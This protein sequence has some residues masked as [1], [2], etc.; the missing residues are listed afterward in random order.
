MSKL[1]D[2]AVAGGGQIARAVQ[3]S[4]REKEQAEAQADYDRKIQANAEERR[5]AAQGLVDA[6]DIDG[7]VEAFFA[8]Q[9]PPSARERLPSMPSMSF[10]SDLV[11]PRPMQRGGGVLAKPGLLAP[12]DVTRMEEQRGQL[13]GADRSMDLAL[14]G[15]PMDIALNAMNVFRNAKRMADET[16]IIRPEQTARDIATMMDN[17]HADLNRAVSVAVATGD[18]QAQQVAMRGLAEMAGIK[19]PRAIT[20]SEFRSAYAGGPR[21]RHAGSAALGTIAGL[22]PGNKELKD[23]I[24]SER[25]EDLVR[26]AATIAQRR[27]TSPLSPNYVDTTQAEQLLAR[28]DQG[29]GMVMT[30]EERTTAMAAMPTLPAASP[31][32]LQ[33]QNRFSAADE[34]G[35]MQR[36]AAREQEMQGRDFR[37]E[38]IAEIGPA[39]ER[40]LFRIADILAAAPSA[41]TAEQR[42]ILLQAAA[43]SPDIQ[44]ANLTDLAK[45]AY[46]DRAM[47]AVMKLFPEEEEALSEL[48]MLRMQSMRESMETENLR[49]QKLQ[50]ALDKEAAKLA[51]QAKRGGGTG[52]SSELMRQAAYLTKN[53]PEWKAGNIP[54]ERWRFNTGPFWNS[55][56]SSL[57]LDGQN[58]GLRGRN[59]KALRSAEKNMLAAERTAQAGVRIEQAQQRIE[60]AKMRARSTRDNAARRY[61]L[62][63]Q[64]FQARAD[65]R[66]AEKRYLAKLQGNLSNEDKRLAAEEYAAEIDRLAS[67]TSP[68]DAPAQQSDADA[69]VRDAKKELDRRKKAKQEGE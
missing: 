44:A 68:L 28:A 7:Q 29:A 10:Q 6:T 50:A 24:D 64:K 15:N 60:N 59:L 8:Q 21:L 52:K 43:D 55:T 58:A 57:A 5:A 49:Q 22:V 31:A 16:N 69:L 9:E 67:K 45:G 33:F 20:D 27:A 30:P 56:P 19:D 37:Q 11:Q 36:R 3:I 66:A 61:N 14:P 41:R 25:G 42:A 38:A 54:P 63:V 2:L 4:N 13:A 32:G 23:F 12:E 47:Q 1:A 48:D 39:P 17:A 26:R 18:L 40:K 53:Y 62:D 35:S 65:A 34:Y 51:R 46:R